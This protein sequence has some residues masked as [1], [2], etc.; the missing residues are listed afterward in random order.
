M[1]VK[2]YLGSVK[3]SSGEETLSFELEMLL[4]LCSSCSNLSRLHFVVLLLAGGS[5]SLIPKCGAALLW[6]I[7]G[8]ASRREHV[9]K[10]ILV[11]IVLRAHVSSRHWGGEILLARRLVPLHLDLF[12]IDNIIVVALLGLQLLFSEGL[13]TYCLVKTRSLLVSVDLVS[14]H[15]PHIDL[16][17]VSLGE[18]K[19]HAFGLSET[20]LLPSLIALKAAKEKAATE[21][22]AKANGYRQNSDEC[23]DDVFCLLVELLINFTD[24]FLLVLNNA[25]QLWQLFHGLGDLLQSCIVVVILEEGGRGHA[26]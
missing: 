24:L 23:I 18:A 25:C 15:S 7:I 17:I 2:S 20:L 19:V 16:V 6:Q 8:E 1:R 10:V 3:L 4:W 26:L 12:S 9:D 14:R 13:L 22:H 11:L 21:S 5:V